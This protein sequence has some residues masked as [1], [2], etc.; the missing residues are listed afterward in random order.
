MASNAQ[1]TY[2]QEYILRPTTSGELS[3]S[4]EA[5]I[6]LDEGS[7]KVQVS[8][9]GGAF[10]DVIT[11]GGDISAAWPVGSVFISV[12]STNPATL[13]GFG[14]WVA[15]AAGR[16]LVGFDSGDADF[17]TLEETG[18]AKTHTLTTGEMPS[19]THTQDAHNHGVTD[20]AHGHTMRHFPTATGGSTGNTVDTSMSGTQTNSTLTTATATT[21]VTVN[22]ATATNQ[23]T[24]GDGAHNNM[25]PFLV[26]RFWKRT[27]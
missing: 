16:M 1:R 9:D 24:G 14:T 20:P 25:P 27:A 26:C 7:G 2:A 8:E 21:G 6:R 23:N 18:G 3:E 10:A 19:H 17:D 4:G 5:V 15:I 13:L 11:P 12:V 22:N